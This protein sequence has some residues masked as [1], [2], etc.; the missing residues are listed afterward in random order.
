MRK[1][2]ARRRRRRKRKKIIFP[3]FAFVP[4]PIDST[5]VLSPF[6]QYN[7]VE[8]PNTDQCNV[9]YVLSNNPEREKKHQS[10]NENDD[11][12]VLPACSLSIACILK[13]YH[14]L[15]FQYLIEFDSYLY[16]EEK[17]I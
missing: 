17:M 15:C 16:L 7:P 10:I 5:R 9:Y 14:R 4:T 11:L 2:N 8:F 13:E 6:A 3:R 1:S 12:H